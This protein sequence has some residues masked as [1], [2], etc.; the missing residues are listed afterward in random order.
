[1]IL[2]MIFMYHALETRLKDSA[3]DRPIRW[4]NIL[5]F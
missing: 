3:R 2:Y 1:M 5:T 4:K